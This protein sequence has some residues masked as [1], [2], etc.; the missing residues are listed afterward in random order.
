MMVSIY[1][2]HIAATRPLDS[3]ALEAHA[4]NPFQP[5]ARQHQCCR[6]SDDRFGPSLR[7]TRMESNHTTV[8]SHRAVRVYTNSYPT[9]H[10]HFHSREKLFS[11][12]LQGFSCRFMWRSSL[13]SHHTGQT[14]RKEESAKRNDSSMDNDSLSLH[15]LIQCES[16]HTQNHQ[17]YHQKHENSGGGDGGGGGGGNHNGGSGVLFSHGR[18]LE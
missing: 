18:P 4:S 3:N 6:R 14:R 17:Q 15:L 1:Q 2:I 16:R 9:A 13:T 12:S 10:L 5:R 7:Q 8:R 11:R